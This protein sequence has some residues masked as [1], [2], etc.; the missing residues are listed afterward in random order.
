[1]D[2]PPLHTWIPGSH[3]PLVIAGPCSAET[4]TQVLQT[5]HALSRL[6]GVKVFRAGIWKPRTRP[7]LF[8]G[9][10]TAG[11]VWMKRVKEET[12]LL[13]TVEVARPGHVEE[14]LAHGIDVL[15]I[16]ARTVVNPFSM[17][18]L[19]ESLA[20]VDIPVM[21]KNPV[22]PDLKLW[23]GAIERLQKNGITRLAAIHRGFYQSEKPQCSVMGDPH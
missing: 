17:Q 20:G 5:A 3:R 7:G 15:W 18:E 14:A 19:A 8:E 12:G 16:G 11:L 10:G 21:V 1:M 23:M 22:N 4:E 13:T 2:F 6:P 9:V